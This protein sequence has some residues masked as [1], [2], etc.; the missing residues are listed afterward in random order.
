MIG[1]EEIDRRSL[2]NKLTEVKTSLI[3]C[4]PFYGTLVM[5]L[6]YG[7][8]KC[9]TACTDM[10]RLL[11]D[12]LFLNRISVEEARFVLVHE[13]MH[14]VLD[15]CSRSRGKNQFLYN[16]ASDIVVNSIILQTMGCSEFSVD[17]VAVMHLAPDGNEGYL[18][19]ADHV[20]DML[21]KKHHKVLEDMEALEAELRSE[22]GSEIDTHD[23]W[24]AVPLT[25]ALSDEW[26]I[27]IKEA[28]KKASEGNVLP[29]AIRSILS[30]VEYAPKFNW[31]QILADFIQI[32]A[33][34]FDYLFCPPDRRFAD[35]DY[36]LPSFHELEG[37][38]VENLWLLIDTSGSI[39]DQTL[40]DVFHEIEASM[41][42]FECMKLKISCFDTSV[43]EPVDIERIE[44]L[45]DLQL[46]GGGGTSFN[47]I[48]SYMAENMMAELPAGIVILTDGYSCYPEESAALE[49]P[50][51]WILIDSEA[52]APWGKS[53]HIHL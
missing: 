15:H 9:G 51:L 10:R 6:K 45:D 25:Q 12:P 3:M 13:I 21:H 48:F 44:D 16:I 14:C 43:T 20:Y 18:Y 52:D 5:R 33:D 40:T 38:K 34:N 7:F 39:N 29:P 37:E 22:Y 30:T 4:S 36:I 46:S 49:I 28:A 11:F 42:Q 47:A 24:E 17:G 23:I 1:K 32:V 2:I 53:V 27:Y 41:S 26:K 8:A 35:T 31:R 50:V 19:I